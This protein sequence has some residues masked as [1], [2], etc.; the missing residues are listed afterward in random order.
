MALV[1][2]WNYV[3][4]CQIVQCKNVSVHRPV[5]K[6]GLHSTYSKVAYCAAGWKG[7][8]LVDWSIIIT[9]MGVCASFQITSAQLIGNLPWMTISVRTLTLI[10]GLLV[11][12]I[13]VPKNI[14]F[15]TVFANAAMVFMIIGLGAIIVNGFYY[16]GSLIGDSNSIAITPLPIIPPTMSNFAMYLGLCS[17]S[18][19]ICT[20][21]I[22]IE[23]SMADRTRFTQAVIYSLVFVW[24]IYLVVGDGI[25]SLYQFDPVG[26]QSNILLNLPPAAIT[27]AVVRIS[28]SLVSSWSSSFLLTTLLLASLFFII[29]LL[30]YKLTSF[31]LSYK[32]FIG[33]YLSVP[34]TPDSAF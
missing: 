2:L 17:Y 21:A 28:M 23:E 22:P 13:S 18:Y 25:A 34:S 24:T 1:G 32:P 16:F 29:Y 31:Q 20:T 6:R 12:P 19:G 9:L 14:Q 30:T 5:P 15:L 26:I 7:V 4:C 10:T 8:Y 11:Y 3:S 33:M 27:S